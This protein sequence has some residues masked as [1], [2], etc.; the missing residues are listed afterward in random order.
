MPF[1]VGVV[2]VVRPELEQ[3]VGRP[4]L[5]SDVCGECRGG[6]GLASP[7]CVSSFPLPLAA[8]RTSPSRKGRPELSC[9]GLADQTAGSGARFLSA[10]PSPG[11]LG[12]NL[13]APF[14]DYFPRKVCGG[15]NNRND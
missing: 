3:P 2:P 13:A 5:L 1:R 15:G 11:C 9:L 7:G 12:S 10:L 8:F 14:P 6:G 4:A